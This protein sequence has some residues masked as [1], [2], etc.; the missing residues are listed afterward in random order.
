MGLALFAVAGFVALLAI[1]MLSVAIAY[2]INW[3]GEGLALHWAFLCVFGG[4]LLLAALLGFIG[5]KKIKK[6]R[7]TR[8]GHRAGPRASPAPCAGRADASEPDER[9]SGRITAGVLSSSRKM[10]PTRLPGSSCSPTL[11][12]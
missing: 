6:V 2:F 11:S 7:G 3:N 9:G 12:E 8:E 1:I 10:V 5:V 4:Y